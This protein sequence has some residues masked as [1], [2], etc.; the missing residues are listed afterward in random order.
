MNVA[1]PF[2]E[3]VREMEGDDLLLLDLDRFASAE[4]VLAG[5]MDKEGGS[6]EG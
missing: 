6:W 1:V 5:P 3:T 4:M 2:R